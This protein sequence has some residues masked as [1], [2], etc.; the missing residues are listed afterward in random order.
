M[1][2]SYKL[3]PHIPTLEFLSKKSA[4]IL[5]ALLTNKVSGFKHNKYLPLA[6][7]KPSL[8]ALPKPIFF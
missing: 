8:F 3:P 1:L 7:L 4:I 2:L 5:M 6:I